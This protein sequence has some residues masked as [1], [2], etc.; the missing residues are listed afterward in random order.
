M[1][2]FVNT[3]HSPFYIVE[4]G[5]TFRYISRVDIEGVLSSITKLDD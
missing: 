1:H 3:L 4:E 2:R 5:K